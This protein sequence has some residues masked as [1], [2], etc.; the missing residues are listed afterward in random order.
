MHTKLFTKNY[1]RLCS[2]CKILEEI[3]IMLH[4]SKKYTVQSTN[5][6]VTK[7]LILLFPFK[8]QNYYHNKL[9]AKIES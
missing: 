4:S 7:F 9:I 5:V 8:T 1:N 6:P 3:L 2:H